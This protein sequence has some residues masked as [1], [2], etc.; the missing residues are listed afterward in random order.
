VLVL[1][2]GENGSTYMEACGQGPVDGVN[3][4]VVKDGLVRRWRFGRLGWTST[5]AQIEEIAE[6]GGKSWSLLLRWARERSERKRGGKKNKK[7]SRYVNS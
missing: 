5:S 7:N 4:L 2:G 1:L 6:I 3:I